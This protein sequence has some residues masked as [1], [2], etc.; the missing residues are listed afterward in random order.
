M[1]P[2][3]IHSTYVCTYIHTWWAGV[4]R[5]FRPLSRD[6]AL[7]LG[8]FVNR[9]RVGLAKQERASVKEAEVKT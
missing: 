5:Y 8:Y 3:S 7:D 6:Q 1:L 2:G 4:S 9:P